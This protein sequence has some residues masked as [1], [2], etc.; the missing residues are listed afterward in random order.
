MKLKYKRKGEKK[1]SLSNNN[2]IF[3]F[4]GVTYPACHGIW[5]HWAP[6]IERSRLATLAFCG[7]LSSSSLPILFPFTFFFNFLYH[8][9]SLPAYWLSNYINIKRRQFFLLLHLFQP[10]YHLSLL[11]FILSPL[12]SNHNFN[13]ILNI[14][15]FLLI[16]PLQDP[17]LELF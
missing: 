1:L 13:Q 8:L 7:T 4:Q 9:I 3:T 17:M 15:T 16:L 12:N 6:P 10:H 14:S 11:I 5:R 2:L